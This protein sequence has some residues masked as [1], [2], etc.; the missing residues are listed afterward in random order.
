MLERPTP[1]GEQLVRDTS[2]E[3]TKTSSNIHM[4]EVTDKVLQRLYWLCRRR[5]ICIT[6]KLSITSSISLVVHFSRFLIISFRIHCSFSETYSLNCSGSAMISSMSIL[7]GVAIP[8]CTAGRAFIRSNHSTTLGNSA[9]STVAKPNL[10]QTS[11]RALENHMRPRMTRRE[12]K[13]R[14]HQ[15]T[16]PRGK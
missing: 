13:K 1:R 3:T 12:K 5:K 16:M 11:Q 9:K 7:T 2:I 10:G 8:L 6:T 14:P 15:L 4:R